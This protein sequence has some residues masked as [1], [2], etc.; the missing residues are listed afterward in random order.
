MVTWKAISSRLVQSD[1]RHLRR[2]D[3]DCRIQNLKAFTEVAGSLSCAGGW[4]VHRA[5]INNRR[6][7]PPLVSTRGCER[8]DQTQ[9]HKG[10]SRGN[11]Q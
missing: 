1:R 8:Q 10:V 11:K 4:Q 9:I 2:Q 5:D 6:E 3:L 7:L